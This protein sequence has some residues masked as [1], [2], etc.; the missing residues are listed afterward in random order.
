[1]DGIQ[2]LIFG[3]GLEFPISS[4]ICDLKVVPSGTF[5]ETM[6]VLI[7]NGFGK[8]TTD[9]VN[10]LLELPIKIA[11]LPLMSPTFTDGLSELFF[12]A[13]WLFWMPCKISDRVIL[14][15]AKL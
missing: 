13:T 9:C 1:V 10:E 12:S 15:E 2:L 6:L 14:L 3:M 7:I 8:A 5:I 4:K 11:T